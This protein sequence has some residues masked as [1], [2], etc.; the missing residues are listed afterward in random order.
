MIAAPIPPD[1]AERLA[2][3]RALQILDTP[4]ELRFDR[5]VGLAA[6]I[7]DVP[8]AYIALI[9]ADR[10]WFKARCGIRTLVTGR[11]ISFCGH[12]ILHPEPLVIPDA[13]LDQ[14]F[15][16]NPLVVGEPFIRFYAGHPLAGPTGRNIGTLCVADRRPRSFDGR[17]CDMLR[18]LA[19]LAEHELQLVDVIEVQHE[20]IETRKALMET[21]K[22][23]DKEL[24]QAADYV[25]SLLPPRL[26]GPI[27][28]DWQF[29]SS[30]RLGGDLFNYY[31]L[32]DGRL[33]VYLLDVCGH[34]VGA[35]LLSISV[36]TALRCRTLPETRFDEPGEVLTA[37]NQ[38]FPMEEHGNRFFTIWYGVFDPGSRTLRFACGGHPPA[39]LLGAGDRPPVKLGTS[40]FMVGAM[41][42]ARY[43]T[44]SHPVPPEGRLYLFSD[45]AFEVAPPDGSQL[46]IDGLLKVIARAPA[47]N[48]SRVA[49]VLSHITALTGSS[50]LADDFSLVEMVID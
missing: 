25:R 10:Q 24:N 4:A 9:D 13:L 2:D 36:H 14:R 15:R 35:A 1:E 32:E 23:L 47:G 38:A 50:D 44:H 7:F 18:Q 12:A 43:D 17:Q 33:V 39:L 37:L 16:D 21:Q 45:G 6:R 49:H 28:S 20:V 31:R 8:I 42:G 27:R 5:I 41:P 26:D 19:A 30:S 40:D 29:V 46:G 34:G 22:R 3:L 11:D 48:G